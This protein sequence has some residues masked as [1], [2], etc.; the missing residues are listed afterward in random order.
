MYYDHETVVS[1]I[2]T[3][4]MLTASPDIM[5]RRA[6]RLVR[7]VKKS[8]AEKCGIAVKVTGSRVGGGALPEED[9]ESR[10]VVLE[11]LDRTVNELEKNLR[12]NPLPV[13]GR[14]E[15]D[16]YILDMRTVA[17]DEIPL[18]ANI[19]GQVFGVKL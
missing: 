18:I 2:P 16:R 13:I 4:K 1:R 14:I 5:N 17:D 11:P 9:L 19:L 15:E 12:M 10:A 3:L 6:K 8:L 7:R